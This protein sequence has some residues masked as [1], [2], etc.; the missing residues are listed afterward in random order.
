MS[1]F[2]SIL[3]IL[4]I[5][6]IVYIFGGTDK[7]ILI[8]LFAVLLT[9]FKDFII[10]IF[11]KPKLKFSYENKEPYIK[12]I[13]RNNNLNYNFF[14]FEVK[15]FG[16]SSALNCKCKIINMKMNEGTLF[17]D[18]EGFNLKWS[19][20]EKYINDE[21]KEKQNLNCGEIS[22]IDLFK[23]DKFNNTIELES[24]FQLY[25]GYSSIINSNNFYINLIFCG[26]NFKPYFLKFEVKKIKSNNIK[27]NL[28]KVKR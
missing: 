7:A 28:L 27:V 25:E 4:G 20:S 24:P 18:Y 21:L 3:I 22:Y 15:N 19:G 8:S 23:F 13:K 5:T 11:V 14:R 6:L 16:E 10:P 2:W 1:E 17:E 26:D 12:F 9:T